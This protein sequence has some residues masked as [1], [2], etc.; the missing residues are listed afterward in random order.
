M[1]R[2]ILAAAEP[3]ELI[4][5]EVELMPLL[6]SVR[7]L[8]VFVCRGDEA[9][10]TMRE[11]GRIRELVF[12]HAGAGRGYERDLDD[13]DFGV[14]SYHQLLVWDPAQSEIVAL[15]RFQ[16]GFR[17]APYLRTATLFDYSTVFSEILL[18][19]AIELGRSVVN[20]EAKAHRFGFFALWAGLQT[21]VSSSP[22]IQYLFGN[23]SLYS[24]LGEPAQRVI[25]DF[26]QQLYRPPQPM[27]KAKSSL[28][29]ASELRQNLDYL[30][31]ASPRER[32]QELQDRLAPLRQRVPK[33]L[34]SYLSLGSKIWFDD[35]A[36]DD[37]FAGAVELSIVVP[38]KAI[39][40][41][42]TLNF[43]QE[44]LR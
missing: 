26:C 11:I 33:V 21:L 16:Y 39:D 27:L 4:E 38:L 44:S 43:Q 14:N 2:Q 3:R 17:G 5:R 37:D 20:P 25:V 29:F 6:T 42:R 9:P 1:L 15:Y 30:Q 28:Y 18:P 13:L 24:Q 32:I 10:A 36:C 41:Q 31:F 22:S 40:P 19:H 7:N 12:R 34:Q 35:A 23:V 8:Q